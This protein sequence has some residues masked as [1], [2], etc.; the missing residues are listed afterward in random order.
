MIELKSASAIVRLRQEIEQATNKTFTNLKE[1][2][3]VVS[4]GYGQGGP[5]IP[6]NAK[7]K[8]IT[9]TEDGYPLEVGVG[10]EGD[11]VT[12]VDAFATS[13]GG[14]PAVVSKITKVHLPSTATTIGQN[15]FYYLTKLK[16]IVNWDNITSIS[17]KGLANCSSLEHTHLPPNLTF[18]GGEGFATSRVPI[19]ELPSALI[20]IGISAFY[21]VSGMNIKKLNEGLETISNGAFYTLSNVGVSFSEVPASVKTIGTQAFYGAC[22]GIVG[23]LKF[24]GTPTTIAANAFEKGTNV[25]DV[26]VPWAEGELDGAPWGMTNATIHYNTVYDENGEPIVEE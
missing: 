25:T 18:I 1:A 9:Y 21:R 17:Y 7:F 6:A 5:E 19:T 13:S 26:Y 4:D 20:T 23:S 22:Q 3:N 14:C 16:E 12:P 11:T 15:G 10:A 2:V 24:R 8:I